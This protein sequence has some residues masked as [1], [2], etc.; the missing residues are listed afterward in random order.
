MSCMYTIEKHMLPFLSYGCVA[1]T[2]GFIRYLCAF[3]LNNITSRRSTFISFYKQFLN[4]IMLKKL[5]ENA[6]LFAFP[7]LSC[8]SSNV[9]NFNL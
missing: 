7:S 5:L 4:R 1:V 8:S 2:I 9:N 6:A 3:P